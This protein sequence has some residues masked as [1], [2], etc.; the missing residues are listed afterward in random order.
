[1]E[2]GSGVHTQPAASS[3]NQATNVKM[4]DALEPFTFVAVKQE[5]VSTSV[6]HSSSYKVLKLSG[7][8]KL[9]TQ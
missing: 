1:M 8:I 7:L 9:W 4:E 6:T 5:V 3:E 2:D